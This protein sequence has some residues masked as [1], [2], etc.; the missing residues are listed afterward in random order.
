MVVNIIKKGIPKKR[1]PQGLEGVVRK[2]K[3]EHA[4]ENFFIVNLK[5][6]GP[7]SFKREDA[8]IFNSP[9]EGENVYCCIL[10]HKKTLYFPYKVCD[11]ENKNTFYEK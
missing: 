7:Y 6:Y 4:Y 10:G 1:L 9:K 8:K 2:G 11:L 5:R 3:I